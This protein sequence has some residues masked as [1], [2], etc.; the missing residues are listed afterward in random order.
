MLSSFEAFAKE[1]LK[2]N[3]GGPKQVEML[4]SEEEIHVEFPNIIITN[5]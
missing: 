3:S 1:Q 5:N 2:Y 4:F